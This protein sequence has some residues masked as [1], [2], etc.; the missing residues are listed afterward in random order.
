M[1]ARW[2]LKSFQGGKQSSLVLLSSVSTRV[3]DL[4]LLFDRGMVFLPVSLIISSPVFFTVV[5]VSTT[6]SWSTRINDML[7]KEDT[8]SNHC[9]L[10][11]IVRNNVIICFIFYALY[12]NLKSRLFMQGSG[13]ILK[14]TTDICLV[15][16]SLCQVRPFATRRLVK[17]RIK[18]DRYD[19]FTVP[20]QKG[21]RTQH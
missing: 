19:E 10:L 9:E 14:I 15:L 11:I 13:I 3:I 17:D 18:V 16:I 6:I 4:L 8:K 5:S 7:Q 21:G 2:S 20:L 1:T 12:S